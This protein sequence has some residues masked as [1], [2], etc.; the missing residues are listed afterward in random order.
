MINHLSG[1]RDVIGQ[2]TIRFPIGHF[3]LVVLWNQASI[4]NGFR[5]IQQRM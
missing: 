1:S 5:D 3:R 2:V 4:Y